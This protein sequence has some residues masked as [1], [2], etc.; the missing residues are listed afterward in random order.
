MR[1][2][3]LIAGT[4]ALGLAALGGIA[5]GAGRALERTHTQTYTYRQPVREIVV[6]GHAGDVDLVRG[7]GR[8]DVRVKTH[9]L[10]ERPRVSRSLA[11]GTLTLGSE[12]HGWV[13][14]CAVDF[15]VTVPPDATVRVR[16]NAGDVQAHG[17]DARDVRVT[18]N[19][20]DVRLDLARAP[21]RLEAHTNAG[22]VR[23]SVPAGRYAVDATT[24]AGDTDVDAAIVRTEDAG[25]TIDVGTNAGDVAVLAR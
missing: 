6:D 5:Y 10:H 23:V 13:R 19:A 24:N 14:V 2:T 12:C 9:Y 4:A 18:T 8:V 25:A 3:I 16:T 15:R 17:I 11:G 22:D 21:R 1:K 7:S 20:G